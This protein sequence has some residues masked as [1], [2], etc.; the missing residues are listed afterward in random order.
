MSWVQ[1]L[2]SDLVAGL[3]R[4]FD[5]F[6]IM[7]CFSGPGGLVDFAYVCLQAPVHGEWLP[8][9][10]HPV[11]NRSWVLEEALWRPVWTR[12]GTEGWFMWVSR[13]PR[14]RQFI[15]FGGAFRGLALARPL[16]EDNS[17]P[18]IFVGVPWID[19]RRPRNRIPSHRWVRAM[20]SERE[21]HYEV[22]C[23]NFQP[24]DG[25]LLA[26]ASESKGKWA[27]EWRKGRSIAEPVRAYMFRREE[28]A[29]AFSM[30][31]G[32]NDAEV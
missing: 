5:S 27:C 8:W 7:E 23:G 6:R 1:Q 3:E 21:A 15:N 4:E 11:G 25:E 24:R 14:A 22:L 2:P 16:S 31:A 19:G 9:V 30:R 10:A 13:G 28:D 26:M 32:V 12:E 20:P 29:V 17:V 18:R